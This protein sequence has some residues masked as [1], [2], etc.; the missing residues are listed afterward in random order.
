MY[1]HHPFALLAQKH[2]HVGLL[3]N[4]GADFKRRIITHIS[5]VGRV[6]GSKVSLCA[7]VCFGVCFCASSTAFVCLFDTAVI[8]LFS[9]YSSNYWWEKKKISSKCLRI[10][11]VWRRAWGLENARRP[12]SAPHTHTH[13][14]THRNTHM[15]INFMSPCWVPLEKRQSAASQ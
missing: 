14:H 4:Q 1:T 6:T 7:S 5:L 9:T 10:F 11:T 3:L 12:N 15:H 13:I 2:H 8:F